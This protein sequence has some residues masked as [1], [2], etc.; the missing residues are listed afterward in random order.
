MF[1]VNTMMKQIAIVTITLISM[2]CSSCTI[3][4][5]NADGEKTPRIT[6]TY[7]LKDFQNISL[8]GSGKI[9]FH[10]GQEYSVKAEA[11][12]AALKNLDIRTEGGR[13]IISQERIRGGK[14]I[15]LGRNID[16]YT[17]TITAPTLSEFKM[18]GSGD[19]KCDSLQSKSLFLSIAGSGDIDIRKVIAKEVTTK[20]AGSGDVDLGMH[21]VDNVSFSIAGSGDISTD[22]TNCGNVNVSIA[23]SG[24]ISLRGNCRSVKQ[25]VAGSGKINTQNLVINGNK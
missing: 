4:V 14:K 17:I 15:V 11:S 16:N 1:R 8:A 21:N 9:I 22:M 23:G 12:E 19:F 24:D 6:K 3:T 7:D 18:A 13:L 2:T 25:N 10:Q 5:K 20:I